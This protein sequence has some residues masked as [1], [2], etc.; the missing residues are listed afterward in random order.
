VSYFH[1]PFKRLAKEES[2][3]EKGKKARREQ[4]KKSWHALYWGRHEEERTQQRRKK[5]RRE[6]KIEQS[7]AAFQPIGGRGNEGEGNGGERGG[8]E[9]NNEGILLI[10]KK[11]PGKKRARR[12]RNS[13]KR[14]HRVKGNGAGRKRAS[15]G[16]ED[17]NR[18][19]VTK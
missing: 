6:A 9:Y 17:G 18:V 1:R 11:R 14:K 7:L 15:G 5:R 2:V 4:G 16:S 13:F 12:K 10:G 8:S 19:K 3:K